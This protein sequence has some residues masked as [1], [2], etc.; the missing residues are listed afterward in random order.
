MKI[1]TIHH[2]LCNGQYMQAKNQCKKYGIKKAIRDYNRYLKA[3]YSQEF[4]V[5]F[6]DMLIELTCN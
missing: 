3:G 6:L 2:S 5:E 4:H 1:E